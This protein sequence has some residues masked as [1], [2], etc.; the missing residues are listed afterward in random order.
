MIDWIQQRQDDCGWCRGYK[1]QAAWLEGKTL[2]E[3]EQALSARTDTLGRGAYNMGGDA[4]THDYI[5]RLRR[6]KG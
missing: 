3:A 4:A 5:E 6:E 1:D 2:A